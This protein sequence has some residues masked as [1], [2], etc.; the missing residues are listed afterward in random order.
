MLE[1]ASCLGAG[2]TELQS[3][4]TGS[5][6]EPSTIFMSPTAQNKLNPMLILNFVFVLL[7]R[8]SRHNTSAAF[9]LVSSQNH[10][11]DSIDKYNCFPPALFL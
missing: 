8:P 3:S 4:W 1:E 5:S 6:N 10:K 7:A 2:G 11:E 9:M